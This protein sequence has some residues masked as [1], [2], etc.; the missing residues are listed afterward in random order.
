MTAF[1]L[2]GHTRDG[3]IGIVVIEVGFDILR[4]VDIA[5]V[6]FPVILPDQFPIGIDLKIHDLGN[7]A[8]RQALR[9][10]NRGN[11]L[12]GGFKVDWHLRQA[13]EDQ[14]LHLAGMGGMQA[15][16]GFIQACL[17]A[18][19]EQQAA[20]AIIGPLVVRADKAFYGALRLL[21][22]DRSAVAADIVKAFTCP[23]SP[24]T[25]MTESP[26]TS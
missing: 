6:A 17:H 19:L 20:I 23:S 14:P 25:M 3:I 8:T 11:R 24:R 15:K 13:D 4:V 12:V 10:G 26:S 16:L 2:F 7:L 22:D 1:S 21:A 18:T 9:L 5:V